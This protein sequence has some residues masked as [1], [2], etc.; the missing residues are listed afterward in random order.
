MVMDAALGVFRAGRLI[1]TGM[2]RESFLIKDDEF[3]AKCA[4]RMHRS[5]FQKGF[6]KAEILPQQFPERETV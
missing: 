6:Q 1:K 2:P 5:L 4:E 3:N